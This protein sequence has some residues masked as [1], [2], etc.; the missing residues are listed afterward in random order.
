MDCPHCGKVFANGP[1]T[2]E[3]HLTKVHDNRRV[4]HA[5][6]VVDDVHIIPEAVD[7]YREEG[8]DGLC[9]SY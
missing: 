1:R 4:M 3:M 6:D 5:E 2:L 9:A 7:D 8:N